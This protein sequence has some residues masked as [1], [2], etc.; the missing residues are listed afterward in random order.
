MYNLVTLGEINAAILPRFQSAE[1][2]T[3]LAESM[4]SDL[5]ESCQDNRC[6]CRAFYTSIAK[7]ID[8]VIRM[9]RIVQKYH[10]HNCPEGTPAVDC[11]NCALVDFTD[12]DRV[13]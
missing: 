5:I 7:Q 12:V 11:S 9:I 10:T 6:S 8:D 4:I 13:C 3:P 2:K 1:F